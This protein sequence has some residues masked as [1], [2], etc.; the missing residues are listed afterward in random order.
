[1]DEPLLYFTATLVILSLLPIALL[2][3]SASDTRAE[4]RKKEMET[5]VNF[6]NCYSNNKSQASYIL[7]MS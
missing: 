1:M 6:S 2:F 3:K 5:E 7:T 4:N